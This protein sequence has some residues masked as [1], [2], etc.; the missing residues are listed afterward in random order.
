MN[1]AAAS[2]KLLEIGEGSF[3]TTMPLLLPGA[4]AGLSMRGTILYA[5]PGGNAALTLG[6][7]GS[8]NNQRKSYTGLAVFRALQ[9]DWIDEADVGI[10]IRNIDACAVDIRRAE[11][12]TI[13]V[14]L[15]GDARGCEDSDL[16]Y[17]RI[18]DN[19]IGLDLRTL[20]AGAWM[21]SLRH[22][23]GHFAC[24]SA[25]N[26]GIGRFGVRLSA[27]SRCL[28]A[29]QRAS[30]HRPGLRAAAPGHAGH[31]RCHPLP[32]G[33]GWPRPDR[34]RRADGSLLALRRAPHRRLL[35]RALRGRLCRHLRL[36]A[37]AR[38]TMPAPRGPVAPCCRCTR[39]RRHSVR[40]G[41]LPRH[42]TSAPAPSAGTAPRPASRA[43]PCSPAI[44][45]GRPPRSTAS[46]SPACPRS[47]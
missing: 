7:G 32:G 9:S 27:A 31:G 33:G 3:R 39:R 45:P 15:V 23:G 24:S 2:G 37:D 4:A 6:D 18:V 22:Q 42:P 8:A 10:R 30:L 21:N 5:G 13:G 46:A 43:W 26:P 16:R 35:R 12:F 40:R 17:G 28:P 41:S 1:A 29:A 14:Q 19:R 47:R 38:W 11:R 36:H 20:T 44:P 34:A 25:T